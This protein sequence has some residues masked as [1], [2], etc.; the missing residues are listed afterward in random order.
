MQNAQCK[1]HNVLFVFVWVLLFFCLFLPKSNAAGWMK[2]SRKVKRKQRQKGKLKRDLIKPSWTAKTRD[3]HRERVLNVYYGVCVCGIVHVCRWYVCVCDMCV[4]ARG[5]SKATAAPT[6]TANL[7]YAAMLDWPLNSPLVL[8][9]IR[10]PLLL[11][12]LPWG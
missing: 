11:S 6:H 2:I 4:S 7:A 9:F 5:N 8:D 10:P 12:S 3:M 1:I